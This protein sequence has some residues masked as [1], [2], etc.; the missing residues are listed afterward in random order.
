MW[1]SWRICRHGYKGA[2]R[3]VEHWQYFYVQKDRCFTA[4]CCSRVPA[5]DKEG[6]QYRRQA[7]D[8]LGTGIDHVVSVRG[9]EIKERQ[10]AILMARED[11]EAAD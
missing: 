2:E 10:K 9:S 6:L 4:P 1:A 5:Q 7:F 3:V 11:E 8:S